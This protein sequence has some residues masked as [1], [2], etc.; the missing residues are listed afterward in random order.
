MTCY[1]HLCKKRFHS[2]GIMRHRAMHRDRKETVTITYS[3]GD[4]YTHNYAPKNT[5]LT[6]ETDKS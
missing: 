3:K 4:T 6:G 5:P 1:C 2:L